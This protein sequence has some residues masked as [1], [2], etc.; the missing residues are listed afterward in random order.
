MDEAQLLE[1]AAYAEDYSN[2]L[3]SSSIKRGS[4]K[5]YDQMRTVYGAGKKVRG[6]YPFYSGKGRMEVI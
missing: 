2:L 1:L 6:Q 4:K 3:I 5:S